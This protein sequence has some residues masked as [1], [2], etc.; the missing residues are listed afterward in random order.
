[1]TSLGIG[2]IVFLCMMVVAGYIDVLH[3]T[4]Q[5]MTVYALAATAGAW[6]VSYALLRWYN[7]KRGPHAKA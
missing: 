3:I 5:A 7:G 4:V 2:G 1:M 6:S